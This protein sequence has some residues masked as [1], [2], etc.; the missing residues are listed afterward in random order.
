MREG[1]EGVHYPTYFTGRQ[2]CTLSSGWRVG[3]VGG[4]DAVLH[5]LQV[6]VMAME[7]G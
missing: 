1:K 4:E 6:M 7:R 2:Q 3:G 5:L